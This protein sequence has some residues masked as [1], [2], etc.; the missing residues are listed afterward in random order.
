MILDS[1][2]VKKDYYE[3][4]FSLIRPKWVL[5]NL[6]NVT[7]ENIKVAVIDSGCSEF[8]INDSRIHSGK[9]FINDMNG[10]K[11]ENNN[12]Y[13]DQLGH[14]TACIDIILQIAPS[15]EILPIK[16]FSSKLETSIE[17]LIE[18]INYSIDEDVN[19]INLSLGTKLSEALYP[20]YYVCEKAKNKGI[21]IISANGNTDIDSYPAIF[22]N[23]ISV[24][25][26]RTQN[27]FHY[28]YNE[29]ELCE[30]V[31]NGFVENALTHMGSRAQMNGNSFAAPIITGISVLL[32]DK[33]Q[34]KELK[35]LRKLLK[36][37]SFTNV[38]NQI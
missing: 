37:F 5:D 24:V 29:D 25:S 27:K 9:S 30:C 33:Y 12:N 6:D 8:M 23:V 2:T 16:V 3:G 32:I 7:G 19:F 36:K 15:V 26:R 38:Q 22:D 11:L 13:L 28:Y 4:A 31:A 18:A 20:L 1:T 34:I 10:F 21:I 35:D 14:G 17:I